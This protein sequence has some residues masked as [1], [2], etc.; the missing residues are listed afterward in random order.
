MCKVSEV[1]GELFAVVGTYLWEA[2][3]PWEKA[4]PSFTDYTVIHGNGSEK[5]EAD[6]GKMSSH[7]VALY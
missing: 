2:T 7:R 5:A 6:K 4:F 3:R 1:P